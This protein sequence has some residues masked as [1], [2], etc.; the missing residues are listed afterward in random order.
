MH[1]QNLAGNSSG[2]VTV[3]LRRPGIE[4]RSLI[5]AILCSLRTKRRDKIG[6]IESDVAGD[7]V[8]CTVGT[9]SVRK[10]VVQKRRFCAAKT[11]QPALTSGVW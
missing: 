3:A 9:F 1:A 11:V 8:E 10:P 4:C 2:K 5:D 6:R 7:N